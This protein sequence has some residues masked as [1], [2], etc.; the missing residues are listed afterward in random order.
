MDVPR[1]TPDTANFMAS[2]TN[3]GGEVDLTA[4]G[5]GVLSTVPGGGHGPMSGTS[6]ATPA[7]TGAAACVLSQNPAIV[8]QARD[9]SRSDAIVRL[10]FR[11]T[12]S[13]GFPMNFEGMGLPR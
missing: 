9:R 11:A 6:M 12:G 3:M 7:A 13:L 8:A 5:V 4:P 1:G 2:F 10:L